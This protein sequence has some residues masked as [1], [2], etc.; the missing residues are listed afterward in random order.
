MVDLREPHNGSACSTNDLLD[1]LAPNGI[2]L[3]TLVC[4]LNA[5]CE[6]CI[7][8]FTLPCIGAKANG[9]KGKEMM[10]KQMSMQEH[11]MMEM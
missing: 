4:R 11:M 2:A 8:I 6:L 9:N 7:T 10:L 5:R 3:L 1:D